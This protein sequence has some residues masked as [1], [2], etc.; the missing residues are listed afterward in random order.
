MKWFKYIGLF[1]LF[2]AAGFYGLIGLSPSEIQFRVNEDVNAPID[3]AYN[4]LHEVKVMPKWMYALEGVKQTQGDGL[5]ATSEYDLFYP[6]GMTMH[7]TVNL[8]DTF[9]KLAVTGDVPDFFS[10]TDDY[11]LEALDSNRTRISVMVKMKALSLGSR[12]MLRTSE[13]HKKNTATNLTA[14]KGYLEK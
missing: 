5:S 7:R 10:R 8:C 9:T 4:A 2:I 3:E 14:L 12:L 6:N 1:M 13:T 11:T